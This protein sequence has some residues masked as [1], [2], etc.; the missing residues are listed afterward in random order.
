MPDHGWHLLNILYNEYLVRVN[1]II[2][3]GHIETL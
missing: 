1:L 3:I 2:E